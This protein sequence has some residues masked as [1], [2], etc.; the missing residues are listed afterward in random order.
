MRH[1]GTQRFGGCGDED[2]YY[3]PLVGKRRLV[4]L[5][6]RSSMG[7]GN[8]GRRG[9]GGLGE[10]GVETTDGGRTRRWW[11]NIQGQVTLTGVEV[12]GQEGSGRGQIES[13]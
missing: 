4:G 6:N 7:P 10:V 13:S 3:T 8:P 12:K 5:R 1:A 11:M 2:V 9:E